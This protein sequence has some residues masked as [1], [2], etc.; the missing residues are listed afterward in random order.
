MKKAILVIILLALGYCV[1]LCRQRPVSEKAIFEEYLLCMFS[2]DFG[3][4]LVGAKPASLDDSWTYQLR[5]LFPE[6]V[7]R[8][9]TFMSRVFAQSDVFIF[10]K[11]NGSLWLIN[12]KQMSE[13]ILKHQDLGA[14]VHERFGGEIGF[15]D[16]LQHSDL[17]LFD[18]LDRR[19][20][21]IAIALGYGRDNGE[22]YRRRIMVGEYLQKYPIVQV[23]P[24]DGFPFSDKVRGMSR[25]FC[26]YL[27]EIEKPPLLPKFRSLDDEWD[28]IKKNE[29][30]LHMNSRPKTP[31]YLCLP[32][33]ISCKSGEAK[34]AHK[35]F[36]R[37]RAKLA[38]LFCHKRPSEAI[39]QAVSQG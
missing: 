1:W 4:T 3:Y 17:P 39:A 36:V 10:R 24:F 16:Q 31:Y 14:F 2:D 6:E 34:R 19:V 23:Y 7:E 27:E 29:W 5:D 38:K 18:L 33:Y 25:L 12:K 13:Q 11:I 22:F 28:W 26:R 35:R 37:A 15:F 21:L 32:A 30:P 9:N 8:A 20:E